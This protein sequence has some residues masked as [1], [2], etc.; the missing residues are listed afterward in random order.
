MPESASSYPASSLH[1]ILPNR[2]EMSTCP[3]IP[4]PGVIYPQRLGS[5]PCGPAP[6][7]AIIDWPKNRHKTQVANSESNLPPWTCLETEQDEL[8]QSDYLVTLN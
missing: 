8:G 1:Q 7:L 4:P 5:V 3:C 6:T 2:V